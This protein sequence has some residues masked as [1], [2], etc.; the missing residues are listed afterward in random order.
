M[1]FFYSFIGMLLHSIWQAG[2]LAFVYTCVQGLATNMHPL[3]RRNLLYSL[4]SV[5]VVVSVFTF[6]I[7]FTQKDFSVITIAAVFSLSWLA[8]YV[9]IIFSVY[10]IVVLYKLLSVIFQ[11]NVFIKNYR[12]SLLKASAELKIFTELKAYQLGIKR[13][14]TIWYCNNIESP[15]TFG[16]LKPMILLP[17]SLVNALSVQEVETIIL[18][19]LAHIKSKDYLLNWL[20]LGMEIIYFFNPFIKLLTNKIKLEREKNCDSQVLDFNY[21]GILYAQTLLKIAQNTVD[22]KSFQL[23]AVKKTSQL[24]QRIQFFSAT[25]NRGFKQYKLNILGW[26]IIPVLLFATTLFIQNKQRSIDIMIP[27]S[28]VLFAPIYQTEKLNAY[29]E[30]ASVINIVPSKK[31][32]KKQ[33]D[34]AKVKEQKVK[35]DDVV[36]NESSITMEDILPVAYNETAD[37]VKEFLYNVETQ[38][39]KMTQS[40][41]LIQRNGRWILEPQWMIVERNAD[42]VSL[43]N[44]DTIFNKIDSIQ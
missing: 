35:I 16:F 33:N 38:Q 29:F 13:K 34:F 14:V 15:I 11:W 30:L 40:Y 21:N 6:I 32:E 31:L 26:L 23:G 42:S 7:Y 18:H 28:K 1:S 39:G 4:L 43:S 36:F 37:S 24:I 2:L 8:N 5:Q 17:F 22:V 41:K 44:T 10:F 3:Q 25:E 12:R 20:L 27:Y 19:E 9:N